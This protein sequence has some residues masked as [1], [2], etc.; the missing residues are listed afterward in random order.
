MYDTETN[1]HGSSQGKLHGSF[2]T[3]S[4]KSPENSPLCR[5]CGVQ[6][7]TSA[8]ILCECEALA[9]LKHVFLGSFSLDPEDIKSWSLGAIYG[10]LVKE[11][12]CPELLDYGAQRARP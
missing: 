6:G 10:T 5:G 2:H 11:Q 1:F 12:G 8:H 9:S 3:F 4:R 7:E